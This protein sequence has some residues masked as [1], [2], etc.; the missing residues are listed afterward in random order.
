MKAEIR[1][2]YPESTSV[3]EPKDDCMICLIALRTG[4]EKEGAPGHYKRNKGTNEV[5]IEE[6]LCQ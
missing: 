2:L 1:N 5:S 4:M 3:L 6:S